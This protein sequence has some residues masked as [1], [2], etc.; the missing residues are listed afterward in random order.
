M[1]L[2]LLGVDLCGQLADHSL[3]FAI[4]RMIVRDARSSTPGGRKLSQFVLTVGRG[5]GSPPAISPYGS[6]TYS[7]HPD[8]CSYDGSCSGFKLYEATT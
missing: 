4:C 5:R 2:F 7:K 1:T 3:Y 8:E 6:S